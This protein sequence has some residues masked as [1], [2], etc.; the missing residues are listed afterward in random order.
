MPDNE[1]TDTEWLDAG[2][3]DMARRLD[4]AMPVEPRRRRRALFWWWS[5]GGLATLLLLLGGWW[6]LRKV[7]PAIEYFPIP[8][9]GQAQVMLPANAQTGIQADSAVPAGTNAVATSSGPRESASPNGPKH[10]GPSAASSARIN[11]A[12]TAMQIGRASCR[13]RV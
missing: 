1:W 11:S 13:E 10:P 2:W 5:G 6:L 4:E 12:A 3:A 7:P 9:T 8:Q